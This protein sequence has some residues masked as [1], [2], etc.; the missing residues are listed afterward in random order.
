MKQWIAA[1]L[2]LGLCVPVAQG[3]WEKYEDVT[4][5]D[6][7]VTL[8]DASR[9][10]A[11]LAY[12]H[13]SRRMNLEGQEYRLRGDAADIF[14]GFAVTPWLQLYGQVGASQARLDDRVNPRPGAGAGGLIGARL[15][16]WQFDGNPQE[17]AWKLT[18]QAAGQLAYR[19]TDDKG[20]GDLHWT[21]TM[22]MVP[23]DYHLTFEYTSRNLY[24]TE[25][26]SLH[27]YAGPAFS[28]VEGTWER[29]EIKRDFEESESVGVV[30]GVELWLFENLAFGARADWFDSTTLHLTARYRF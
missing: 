28:T 13:M 30:A 23:L 4:A 6:A 21:E 16:L 11:G 27:A 29:E 14:L 8:S 19:T 3:Q 18:L 1:G 20:G 26:H 24:M 5:P 22:V 25:F 15:N 2:I 9:W 17:K 7:I 10:E 12:V